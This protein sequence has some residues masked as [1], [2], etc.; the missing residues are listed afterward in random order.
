MPGQRSHKANK[1]N[2]FFAGQIDQ[3]ISNS[4]AQTT[5]PALK[6]TKKEVKKN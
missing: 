4:R 2:K 6:F 5:M 3:I 1:L